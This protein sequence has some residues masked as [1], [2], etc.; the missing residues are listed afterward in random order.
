M[1]PRRSADPAVSERIRAR[2]LLRGWSV[3]Y[4]ASRAGVSHATW[5]RIERGLQAADNRFMLAAIAGALECAPADLAG[6]EVPAPDRATAA[7]RAGVLALRRVLVD[8][9]L[10]EPPAGPAPP[11]AE[12]GRSVAL[13]D[14]LHQATRRTCWRGR[15]PPAGRTSGDRRW[16]S[17]P[18]TTW[19]GTSIG[20]A[21]RR[22][23]AV[24]ISSP[25]WP[26]SA[27]SGSTTA[28]TG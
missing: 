23:S 14:A 15:P 13:A 17:E 4:A 3:R 8:I 5:S 1:T 6:A 9:D 10:T 25:R 22:C 26:A 24:C 20:P 16:P 19:A 18:W 21:G 11:V 7:A 28:G 2:R 27:G 12:L